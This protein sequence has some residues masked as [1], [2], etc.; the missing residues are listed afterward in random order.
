MQTS[1]DKLLIYEVFKSKL[2]S[3]EVGLRLVGEDC[4]KA[5]AVEGHKNTFGDLRNR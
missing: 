5:L 3:K 4:G 2:L 1:N